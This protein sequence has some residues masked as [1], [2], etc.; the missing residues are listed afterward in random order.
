MADTEKLKAEFHEDMLDLLVRE[1]GL[2][3]VPHAS[4]R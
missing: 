2:G 1:R 3:F 4:G